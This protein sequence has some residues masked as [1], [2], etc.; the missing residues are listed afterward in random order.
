M[1]E[2]IYAAHEVNQEIIAFIDTIVAECG[3]QKHAM[4]AVHSGRT[5][6]SHQ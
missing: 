1:I 2:A 3:K 5:V 4:R 6:C